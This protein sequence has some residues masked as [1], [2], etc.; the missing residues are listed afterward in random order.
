MKWG[1]GESLRDETESAAKAIPR[2]SKSAGRVRL[3]SFR[4]DP[5]QLRLEPF[6]NEELVIRPA[7]RR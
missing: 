1:K 4:A 3:N 5:E 6:N 2:P 7:G